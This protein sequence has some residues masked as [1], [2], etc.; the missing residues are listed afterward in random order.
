MTT[1]PAQL[2]DLAAERIAPTLHDRPRRLDGSTINGKP[3]TVSGATVVDSAEAD[4]WDRL[5]DGFEFLDWP[6]EWD[7]HQ[8]ADALVDGL[9]FPGR[10]TQFAAKAKAGKSELALFVSHRLSRGIDPFTGIT[11]DPITVIYLDGEMGRLDVISR[12]QAHGLGCHDVPRLAYTDQPLP[13][14]VAEGAQVLARSIAR[15][16]AGLLVLD[17]L[18]AFIRGKE[19]D[20]E[21]WRDLYALAVAP[22]KAKGLAILSLDNMGHDTTNGARGSSVKADK[23][24]IVY[25][26]HRTEDGARLKRT[27][28]RTSAAVEEMHLILRGANGAEP[29]SY[30]EAKASWPAGTRELADLLDRLAV[31]R[32]ATN[33]TARKALREADEKATNDVLAAAIRWRKVSP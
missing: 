30:R 2:V 14:N 23:A 26:L 13:L 32:M 12:L 28:A 17:G 11:I 25:Q 15:T 9:L 22:A 31:P 24:D 5:R 21:E 27:H 10:W 18:N 3:S 1:I 19:N 20:A 4:G 6:T 33:V 7:A 8:E 16:G 29:I